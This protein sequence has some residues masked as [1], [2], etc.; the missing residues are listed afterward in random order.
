MKW[1][2]RR[3]STNIEDQSDPI[4]DLIRMDNTEYKGGKSPFDVPLKPRNKHTTKEIEV[5]RELG[6]HNREG[7]TPVPTPRP[8]PKTSRLSKITKTQVTP[9]KWTTN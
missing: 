3:Q 6:K 1:R 2:G 8:E 4:S 5:A 7:T 9:G